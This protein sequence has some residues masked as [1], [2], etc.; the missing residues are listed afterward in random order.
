MRA[1]HV[2]APCFLRSLAR[3]YIAPFNGYQ[4]VII[5][6]CVENHENRLTVSLKRKFD[7][8]FEESITRPVKI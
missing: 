7:L 2:H 6:I 3:S 4:S 1:E 8:S 5:Y